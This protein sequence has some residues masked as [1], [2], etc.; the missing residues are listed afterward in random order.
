MCKPMQQ[1]AFG[2]KTVYILHKNRI[3]PS[4]YAE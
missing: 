4:F 1:A 3:Y 2:E